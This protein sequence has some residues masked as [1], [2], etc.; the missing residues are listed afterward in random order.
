MYKRNGRYEKKITLDDGTKKTFYGATEREV[1]QKIRAY[2]RKQ[3][4]GTHTLAE[5]IAARTAEE[6]P[7]WSPNTRRAEKGAV[8]MISAGLLATDLDEIRAKDVSQELAR[9]AKMG[10]ALKTIKLVRSCITSAIRYAL[11]ED[12]TENNP[13]NA[14][15]TPQAP[16]TKR[17]AT[18][19][20]D[21]EKIIRYRHDGEIN[22]LA[23]LTLT[24]GLRRGEALA[25]TW[26]DIDFEKRTITVNKTACLDDDLK[27]YAKKPKSD[28]GNRIVPIVD[29]LYDD[30]K[31]R[32]D[33]GDKHVVNLTLATITAR[34]EQYAEDLELSPGWSLHCNRHAFATECV[35]SGVDI[36]TAQSILGHA[37]IG[38][39]LNIYAEVTADMRD[40]AAEKLSGKFAKRDRKNIV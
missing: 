16:E 23:F 8:K 21:A 40:T 25:L 5:A 37:D 11:A 2:V 33:A 22:F 31:A 34:A 17:K 29:L 27:Q 28:A 6:S 36:K 9:L 10:Y 24:T 19:D 12:W 4:S 39:T 15:R 30:L 32:R 3:E 18:T 20:E 13:I 14:I 38:T 7:N 26:N 35:R 1:K